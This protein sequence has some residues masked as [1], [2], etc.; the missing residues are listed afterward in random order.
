MGEGGSDS[1]IPPSRNKGGE[2]FDWS[3]EFPDGHPCQTVQITQRIS[4]PLSVIPAKAG[5]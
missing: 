2:M 4:D 5:I 1:F 3:V